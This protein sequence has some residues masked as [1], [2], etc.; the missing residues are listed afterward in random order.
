MKLRA[1]HQN[2]G[3]HACSPNFA[4]VPKSSSTN[5]PC[6][7]WLCIKSHDLQRSVG[8]NFCWFFLLKL[9]EIQRREM[10][11][12]RDTFLVGNSLS[13]AIEH[14][15]S[16]AAQMPVSRLDQFLRFSFLKM[17]SNP[18][19][20]LQWKT[21]LFGYFSSCNNWLRHS[22]R[23]R[24]LGKGMMNSILSSRP[25]TCLALTGTSSWSSWTM[26]WSFRLLV[27]LKIEELDPK[28]S[29]VSH[30]NLTRK[31]ISLCSDCSRRENWSHDEGGPCSYLPKTLQMEDLKLIWQH[32][33]RMKPATSEAVLRISKKDD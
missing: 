5:I 14:A 28:S 10:N 16:S 4:A 12:S 30:C 27:S 26:N 7:Q 24:F 20:S 22:R 33:F 6:M 31:L 32:V 2:N 9:T 11:G 18:L 29:P 25:L 1:S 21:G 13:T 3:I 15:S 17:R 19:N 23:W 8:N